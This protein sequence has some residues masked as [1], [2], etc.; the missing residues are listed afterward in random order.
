[1]NNPITILDLALHRGAQKDE[2]GS[3][4]GSEIE[5]TGLPFLGGC[6]VCGACVG[7]YNACPSKSGYLR[8]ASECIG[9]TGF[10]TVEEA[11]Q[12]LF[13]EESPRDFPK[14]DK[15]VS[16]IILGDD[17]SA[18]LTRCEGIWADAY[19]ALPEPYQSDS[20]LLFWSEDGVLHCRP[21]DDQ[22]QALGSWVY[23]FNDLEGPGYPPYGWN[24][25][26]D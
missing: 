26:E 18:L 21:K 14:R 24:K 9:D 13:P 2:D 11:N 4:N 23:Y 20:C 17:P 10:A 12:A 3:I 25:K 1:M 19:E 22:I 15:G 8:C 7:A 6:E 5:K 16:V